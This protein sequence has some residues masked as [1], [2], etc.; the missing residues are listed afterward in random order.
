MSI[1]TRLMGRIST[2]LAAVM[3]SVDDTRAPYEPG[4]AY[5]AQTRQDLRAARGMPPLDAEAIVRAWDAK[6]DAERAQWADEEACR[7]PLKE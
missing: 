6:S 3:D 5:Y 7:G 1:L 4:L 2:H